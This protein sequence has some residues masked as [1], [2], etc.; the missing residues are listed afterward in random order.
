VLVEAW[1]SLFLGLLAWLAIAFEEQECA[2]EEDGGY[3]CEE[4]DRV[5]VGGL[6]LRWGGGG[7]V[8]ALGAALGVQ[9]WRGEGEE[10]EQTCSAQVGGS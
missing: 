3:S 9:E 7:V 2:A 8:A 10:E 6:G 4:D 5:A 1:R